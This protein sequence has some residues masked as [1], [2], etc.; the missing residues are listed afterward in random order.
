MFAFA[1]FVL[2]ALVL[3]AFAMRRLL[4]ARGCWIARAGGTFARG[5]RRRLRLRG[6]LTLASF[7]QTARRRGR[8]RRG[9]RPNRFAGNVRQAQVVEVGR[10]VEVLLGEP[11]LR[12]HE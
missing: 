8:G 9:R 10:A 5:W 3:A 7:R 2:L 6:G 1:L 4:R 11:R 12:D